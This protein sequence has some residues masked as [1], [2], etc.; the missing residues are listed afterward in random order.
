MNI[1]QL[2][3]SQ[4]SDVIAIDEPSNE[5]LLSVGN[6]LEEDVK[7]Y[8]EITEEND[9]ARNLEQ[10]IASDNYG[11]GYYGQLE[12]VTPVVKEAYH[13]DSVSNTI[14]RGISHD[15]H[16]G[17]YSDSFVLPRGPHEYSGKIFQFPWHD[18]YSSISDCRT[19][20]IRPSHLSGK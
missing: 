16:N 9:L 20:Y 18:D 11:L 2:G 14:V 17:N 13:G 10:R 5:L 4:P 12:T 6:I 1:I 8:H 3:D 7:E 19:V 15:D